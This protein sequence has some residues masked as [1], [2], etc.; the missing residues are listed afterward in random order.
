M[1]VLLI[2]DVHAN[3]HALKAVADAEPDAE[4]TLFAGDMVDFGYFP[5]EVIEWFRSRNCIV[6]SGNHDREILQLARS[7]K[8]SPAPGEAPSYA[9][10]NLTCMTKDDL[11]YLASLPEEARFTID[12]VAYYMAHFYGTGFGDEDRIEQCYCN[13]EFHSAFETVW[14][15]KAGELN[16]AQRRI[17]LGHTHR[18]VL[19]R[20]G[21]SDMILN[22]GAVG[23]QLGADCLFSHG[24]DYM[25]IED[26]QVSARH[27]EY[28]VSPIRRMLESVELS[29][30]AKNTA[31]GIF[32]TILHPDALESDLKTHLSNFSIL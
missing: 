28:D 4:M 23:Y 17:V 20:R 2:S 11:D 24:A 3:F 15:E 13:H 31:E 22:P 27:V 7:E 5:H 6:V 1:K 10:Y 25:V 14:R 21:G 32:H 26:G 19:L 8:A 16:G 12:G 30:Q 18:S 29:Q 9:Q